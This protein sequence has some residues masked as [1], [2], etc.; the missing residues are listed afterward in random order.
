MLSPADILRGR[1]LIVDDQLPHVLL[2]E[3]LLRGAG[4]QSV[5]STLDATKVC[6]LHLL[7]GYDL[8]LL[9][10]QMPGMDGFQVME[11]LKEIE[12]DGYLPVLVVTAQPGHKLRALQAGAR[13]FISK[14]FDFPEVLARVH[15]QLE[16][17]LLH[18]E[19]RQLHERLLAEQRISERLLAATLPSPLAARLIACPEGA[20]ERPSRVVAES[21]AEVTML[22]SD[23]VE[24]TRYSEGAD[25]DVL[26]G[27]FQDICARFEDPAGGSGVDRIEPLGEARLASLGL[28]DPLADHTLLAARKALDMVEA[29]DRFNAHSRYKLKVRIGLGSD[30]V[31]AG[32]V[33]RREVSHDL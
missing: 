5:A 14:P 25:A 6:E 19:A 9:D 29:L 27:V 11:N 2:L 18:K 4:Y 7:H 28:Q 24:F 23:I 26:L 20:A 17:R 1:I 16:V 15:N 33:I 8:I 3:Q 13:D 12:T 21:F 22:F 31:E 30:E 10:L 32:L